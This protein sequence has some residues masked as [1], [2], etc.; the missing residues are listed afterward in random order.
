MKPYY[1]VKTTSIPFGFKHCEVGYVI[2]FKF[3]NEENYL[4][5]DEV[6]IKK[7]YVKFLKEELLRLLDDLL[8]LY[9]PMIFKSNQNSFIIL[10]DNAD[11]I[12]TNEILQKLLVEA[13]M[14]T[15]ETM[16]ISASLN[17]AMLMLEGKEATILKK[18]KVG[19]LLVDSKEYQANRIYPLQTLP[20]SDLGFVTPYSEFKLLHYK[21]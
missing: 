17:M 1:I 15:K 12:R 21:K 13:N 20:K 3:E 11:V 9:R 5:D 14:F 4:Q 10:K 19:S 6:E 18:K 8:V 7:A 2:D 16:N